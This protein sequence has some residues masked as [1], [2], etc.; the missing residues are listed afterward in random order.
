MKTKILLT[1]VLLTSSC[2]AIITNINSG[3]THATLSSAVSA[4][5]S[6]DTLLVS[7]GQYT[8]M[9]IMEKNL[10]IIGGYTPDFSVQVSYD[11]TILDGGNYCAVFVVSTST[12]EGLTF[13][14]AKFGMSVYNY[15]IVT[16]RHC[17]VENNVNEYQGGG[18]KV[19]GNGTLVLEHTDVENNSATN[20]NGN[21]DGGGAYVSNGTLILDEYSDIRHN[22][23]AEKG[24]GI[25]VTSS[26]KVKAKTYSSIY[27]NSADEAGGGV[28]LNGGEL[29][30]EGG[31]Y[32]GNVTSVPNR[33]PGDGGGIFAQDAFMFFEG[34]FSLANNYSGN[35]GGGA[36]ITNSTMVFDHSD[37]GSYSSYGRT[38]FAEN[39]GG[40]IYAIASTLSMTNSDIHS[41]RAGYYGGAIYSEF[42]DVILHNCEV[43]NTNDI[44]TNVSGKDGGAIDVEDGSL[45]ISASTFFNNQAD[46]D[47]GAIRIDDSNV[48]I[49]NSVLRNN[50][51]A[52]DGG[53]L[54]VLSGSAIVEISDSIIVTNFGNDGGGIYWN[55][56]NNLVI[57]SSI[58]NANEA[59]SDG[60]G[61]YSTG[62]GLVLLDDV[63]MLSNKAMDDGG[64]LLAKSEQKVRS[65]DCD[66]RLNYADSDGNTNGNG[67]GFAIKS[68][69]KLEII[70]ETKSVNIGANTAKDGA[71]IY[72]EEEFSSVDIVSTS[73]FRIY[74]TSNNAADDGGAINATNL[75][76]TTIIGNVR[77]SQN[78]AD[79]G[80]GIFVAE[81]AQ[82]T[83]EKS[84]NYI[85]EFLD[86]T[87]RESGGG[88]FAVD[89]G[90]KVIC[91]GVNFGGEND[92]NVSHGTGDGVGGGAVAVLD[93]AEFNA[94]DCVFE[95]NESASDGGAI[96][97]SNATAI[98][99]GEIAGDYAA[100]LPSSVLI[101]NFSSGGGGS[102]GGAVYVD[103][104][105][106][107]LYNT[108]IISN[109]AQSGGG[110]YAFYSE[111]YFE[112]VMLSKNN[113]SF[114]GGADAV[115]AFGGTANIRFNYCTIAYND[116]NGALVGSGAELNMT[117][118]IVWGHT[119]LNVTTNPFQNVVSS[120]IQGGCPGL[121]NI[122]A[123]PFFAD[124][125]NLD[126][127]LTANSPCT[128]MAVNIG[129]TNDCIGLARPQ[130]GGY[131][132]GAY[133]FIPEP[134]YFIFEILYLTFIICR[135][136]FSV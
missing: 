60:G 129:I 53:V 16:A 121:G 58:I 115:R 100:Q 75:S 43:G 22:S 117:N 23:A 89:T 87:A 109:N 13:T 84:G 81:E 94:I 40:G 73:G 83:L 62:T 104:G 86:C 9:Y 70:A 79:N 124:S 128:N 61:I 77:I 54:Y 64:A 26:G 90:T 33:T 69:A 80:A 91:E 110:A 105:Y 19:F 10:T 113:A 108:A 101:N 85:P 95:E 11:D 20:N 15:S 119:D 28:Y 97:V 34:T 1:I 47:G 92:G 32:I 114:S 14:D 41:S 18:V 31:A 127:Q 68:E 37:I 29:Y 2:F 136:K 88:I 135:R 7:T 3:T 78:Q 27:G 123:P 66:I 57:R 25:Y 35:N 6:D 111:I 103:N 112:N 39:N 116:K 132:M 65:I 107:E 71:G 76:E 59:N 24:G 98:V 96:Y 72:V 67:G 42:S 133:E 118:C 82:V 130:L 4:A 106:A 63:E 38:N 56:D 74:M 30:M 12:V 46:D 55:S 126:Y 52:D 51:A 120:D 131:D 99:R 93:E 17:K 45:F 50:V 8:Y 48:T 5:A 21:G 102:Y 36:Y 122:S 44:Y 134:G 49:T 125:A